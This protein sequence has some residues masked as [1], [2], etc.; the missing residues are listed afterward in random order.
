MN[1]L[2]LYCLLAVTIIPLAGGIRGANSQPAPASDDYTARIQP[3][4]NNRCIACHSCFNA[5]CQLNLQSYSG[6]ARGATK[7]NVYD[8]SRASS[9]APT[10][11]DIDGHSVSDWRAKGFF[12]VA[13]GAD[14]ARTLLMQLVNLRAR[15]PAVQPKKTV[16]ESNFCPAD[17]AATERLS[18]TVPEL[19]MPYG[20]PP[21]SQTEMGALDEWLA[22]GAPG[23]SDASLASQRAVPRELQSEVR[24]W[25]TFLNGSTPREKL[26]ARYLYEH[27][28]LAHLYFT[29]AAASGPPAFFRLVRSRTPCEAGIDEIATRRPNDNP[30]AG[31]FQYCL[32]RYDGTIVDKAHIPYDLSPQKLE[33]IRRTFLGPLWDVKN[34]PGYADDIAGNPF[35]T[36]A[37]I[38]VRSRYQFLLDDAEYEIKTFIK[39]PVCNGSIAVNAIQEQFFVFFLRPD[40]DGMVVS[41]DYAR[42]A[43]DLLILPGVWGSDVSF[44]DD[45]PFLMRLIRYREDYRKLRADYVLKLRPAGYGIADIWNGDGDNPN[46]LLTVLR[47][48]DNA[49]VTKGAA[50]DLP[51]TLF[52]LDYPLFERLVYNLVVNYDVFGNVGHQ[53]LTR[54]Y[55]DL[56]RMEA[57][58]LFLSFLPPSQ[59]LPLRRSWYRGGLFTELKLRYVFPLL[60][61]TAPTAVVYR[62]EANAKEELVEQII[63]EYLSAQVRGRPDALNWKTLPLPRGA[64]VAPALTAPE[65]ALRR[66]ASIKAA[67][68]TPFARFLPDLAVVQVHSKD[69]Q[70]RLYSLVHNREHEN[71]SWI[72]GELDRL[73]PQEDS[74]TVMAGVPGAYPNMFFEVPEAEIGLFSRTVARIRSAADY[75][76]L[77]DRF[78]VRRSNQK[79]WT[80][81]DAI[82][83]AHLAGDSV[84][85]GTLDLTRYA[86]D[87]K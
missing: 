59:R 24:D 37:D 52:V 77:V 68:A 56:I 63:D 19:G 39:G 45:I 73:A 36:F 71:V 82:N 78:G 86:L 1:R 2:R 17:G 66:I 6:L 49:V 18:R 43:R 72:L 31:G 80:V 50:G 46:A 42:K 15:H 22:R 20:L 12:G 57:E 75:E 13:G 40:A 62:H 69:G 28:F 51:K 58:E 3:I 21:L 47:H 32:M 16:S 25:E 55:M 4:F 14:P 83:S 7:L 76:R 23:P 34:L 44:L 60:D 11:L 27:L 54:L 87:G 8:R 41:A 70:A 9:V 5:P 67:R 26:T 48:F 85:S 64:T 35:A 61:D 10:R 81:Y 38:P 29:S 65:Q 79:F 74:L 84:Q 33:R 53:A 30:G